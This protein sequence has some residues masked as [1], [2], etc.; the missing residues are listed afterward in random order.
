MT[1]AVAMLGTMRAQVPVTGQS[2]GVPVLVELFTSEGCSSCPPA[3]ALLRQINGK[4]IETGQRIIALSE[5]VTYWNRLG[6]ADPFSSDAL[7]Q[8]QSDYGESFHLDD[9][10]TPQMVV[11]GER[12]MSGNDARAV[13][14]AVQ[15]QHE[16]SPVK[17]EILAIEA[18]DKANQGRGVRVT[19]SVSGQLPQQGLDVYAAMADDQDTTQVRRGENAGRTLT[20]VSVVRSL[21][22]A[23]RAKAPKQGTVLL[24]LPE[25][26]GAAYTGGR[27]VVVFVQLPGPGKVMS[28]AM[29]PVMKFPTA[30]PTVAT[31]H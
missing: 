14:Q 21:V 10:Y 4:R 29:R 3:D 25:P 16:G 5:H 17:V 24:L 13:Q 12:Q 20:H 27:H 31:V 15:A 7:T 19:Y 23:E 8:R 9:V 11:N 18:A 26:A 1:C 2:V 30:E 22:R 28:V 6:W